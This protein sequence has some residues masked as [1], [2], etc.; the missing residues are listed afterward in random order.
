MPD[1]PNETFLQIFSSL[2]TRDLKQTALVCH[3]FCALA[4]GLLYRHIHL[5]RPLRPGDMSPMALLL[6]TLHGT[7]TGDLSHAEPTHTSDT[8]SLRVHNEI[9]E[10]YSLAFSV[11]LVQLL[12][13]LP[14]L[15]SLE[16]FPLPPWIPEAFFNCVQSPMT[17]PIALQNIREFRS[18]TV[19]QEQGLSCELLIR[20]MAL[21]SLRTLVVYIDDDVEALAIFAGTQSTSAVTTLELTTTCIAE[22]ILGPILRI[23][24]ALASFTYR[25]SHLC[26]FHLNPFGEAL[27]PVQTSLEHLVLDFRCVSHSYST[28]NESPIGTFRAWERLQTLDVSMMVLF[29]RGTIGSNDIPLA[30]FLP[31]GLRT[32]RIRHDDHWAAGAVAERVVVLLNSVGRGGGGLRELAVGMALPEEWRVLVDACGRAGVQLREIPA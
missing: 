16:L 5:P 13:L 20:L 32:L 6:R 26:T 10:D 9:S 15:E 4:L 28:Y 11:Q 30:S 21:P 31:S 8:R 7:P 14:K 29:G 23:P 27:A 18:T 17:L 25:V 12:S 3:R 19:H 22:E 24:R 1:L 2:S